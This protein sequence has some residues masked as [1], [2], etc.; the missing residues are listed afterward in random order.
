MLSEA[1][2]HRF[3]RQGVM[4]SEAVGRIIG[5]WISRLILCQR[6]AGNGGES[7]VLYNDFDRHRGFQFVLVCGFLRILKRIS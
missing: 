4:E 3:V 5:I 7:W 6:I 1:L 2:P